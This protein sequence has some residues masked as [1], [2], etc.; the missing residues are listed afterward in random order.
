MPQ[1]RGI[2]M[3]PES[4]HLRHSQP[5]LG[6]T[7]NKK[8]PNPPVSFCSIVSQPL[9]LKI[10]KQPALLEL[11]I[12]NSLNLKPASRCDMVNLPPRIT[13]IVFPRHSVCKFGF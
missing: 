2:R 3:R 7:L 5:I 10:A 6:E 11:V 13:A 9:G 1:A 8:L 4:K 12:A